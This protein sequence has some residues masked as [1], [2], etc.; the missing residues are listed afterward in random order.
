MWPWSARW[1]L[2]FSSRIWSKMA[3]MRSSAAFSLVQSLV[4]MVVVPLN[5]MCSN[6]CAMPVMPFTSS[7]EPTL[8]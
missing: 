1:P 2:A 4:P 7:T 6:M 3:S 5:A 8:A